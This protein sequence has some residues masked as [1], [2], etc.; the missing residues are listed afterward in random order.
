M[1]DPLVGWSLAGADGGDDALEI[2]RG[3]IAAAQEGQFLAVEIGIVPAVVS[4]VMALLP[5]L[6]IGAMLPFVDPDA[7]LAAWH[8]GALPSAASALRVPPN[9]SHTLA[10]V[11]DVRHLVTAKLR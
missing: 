2:H 10:V 4:M 11:H 5:T 8:A 6:A 3:G 9:F 7:V 1:R